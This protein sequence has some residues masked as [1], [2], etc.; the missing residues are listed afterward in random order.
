LIHLRVENSFVPPSFIVSKEQHMRTVNIP[1]NRIL[2]PEYV[3]ECLAKLDWMQGDLETMRFHHDDFIIILYGVRG[4]TAFCGPRHI[5][6]GSNTT[7]YQIWSP[8]LPLDILYLGDGGSGILEIDKVI[9]NK[10]AMNGINPFI[11]NYREVSSI[12]SQIINT[13]T[14]YHY[15]HLHM[16]APL[17]GIFNA[18]SIPKQIIGGNNPRS[19]FAKTFKRPMFP[20]DFGEIQGAFS[21]HHIHDPRSSVIIFTPEGE[22]R[23]TSTSDFDS[24]LMARRQHIRQNKLFSDLDDCIV[25]KCHSTDHP[26]PCV[27]YRY[28]NYDSAGKCVT[29]VT[30]LTDHEIRQTD[31]RNTY[32]LNHVKNSDA[33]YFDGQ[34]TNDDFLPGFGH[35]RVEIIG[36]IA[37]RLGLRNI[38]IGHH[39][40][41]RTDEEIDAMV[42]LAQEK[43]EPL[44]EEAR[45]S[46]EPTKARIIGASD[47]IMFFVP[48]RE[49]QRKGIVFGRM[50][51]HK[52]I[53]HVDD[54]G[55]QSSVVY[56]YKSYDLTQAYQL[57][58][59]T[60]EIGSAQRVP[61]ATQGEG[62]KN[63]KKQ[64]EVFFDVNLYQNS[65]R[66]GNAKEWMT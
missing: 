61:S 65:R 43:Y 44:S 16:G 10:L 23:V 42:A 52:G 13:Y 5:R 8:K 48:S 3:I 6:Y 11:S 14:H 34:Y 40:P 24:L 26:D 33:V 53:E 62:V 66:E 55:P 39:D 15:D 36:E 64:N 25:V 45:N 32:F 56:Q 57:E 21:F 19:Q 49:R 1:I 37:A 27:S 58:D 17:T 59:F 29:A 2:M 9:I 60:T 18:N 12:I 54:I 31:Y 51:F 41:K 30:F 35:G 63:K 20:R 22:Y 7:A 50:E 46:R 4:S 38:V 28:E 47:R